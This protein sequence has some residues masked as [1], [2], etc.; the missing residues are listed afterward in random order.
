V[1]RNDQ[2]AA[3]GMRVRKLRIAAGIK[4]GELGASL[5]VSHQ[6][7]HKYEIGKNR[8]SAP[9]LAKIAEVLGA[10]LGALMRDGAPNAFS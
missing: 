9:R 1:A 10:D 5:N 3:I 8:L 6:Q 2:D 4:Q 7:M